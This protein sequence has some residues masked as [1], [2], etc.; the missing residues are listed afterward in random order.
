M[1]KN[2]PN[3]PAAPSVFGGKPYKDQVPYIDEIKACRSAKDTEVIRAMIDYF[4]RMFP[5]ADFWP[6]VSG[7]K[8]EKDET[9]NPSKAVKPDVNVVPELCASAE[10]PASAPLRLRE[11][12]DCACDHEGTVVNVDKAPPIRVVNRAAV[13]LWAV[14]VLV[15]F[16]TLTFFTGRLTAPMNLQSEASNR[17]NSQLREELKIA[18][19][20][21]AMARQ[22]MSTAQDR[23]RAFEAVILKSWSSLPP[24]DQELLE[25]A[26][27]N[28]QF[29]SARLAKNQ[30]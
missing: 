27:R 12:V 10:T 6:A 14:A 26:R 16:C 11:V 9:V 7:A 18:Q 28:Q 1:K 21:A 30:R 8:T 24:T 15:F 17:V 5:A 13:G 4:S 22:E 2:Q 25:M 19:V 23:A 20:D 29:A 3:R